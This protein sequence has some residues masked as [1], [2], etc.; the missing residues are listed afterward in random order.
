MS[1]LHDETDASVEHKV[2]LPVLGSQKRTREID[3]LISG[4]VA[5]YPLRVAI[6]CKNY[7]SPIG[8]EKIDEF[9]GKL[10]DVGIPP[11]CGIFVSVSGYTRD[12]L[13][14]AAQIGIRPLILTGLTADRLAREVARAFQSITYL[15]CEVARIQVTSEVDESEADA[16]LLLEDELGNPCGHLAD[17]I[18]AQWR[19]GLVP[20]EL[21]EYEIALDLPQGWHWTI[22][23]TMMPNVAR[24][25]VRVIGLVITIVGEAQR[26]ALSNALTRSVERLNVR[27]SFETG[28]QTFPVT[29]VHTE[30][31][32][33]E[34]KASQAAASFTAVRL[35]L[36]RIRFGKL[37]WPPS[38]RVMAILVQRTHELIR[39]GNDLSDLA[40]LISFEEIEGTDLSAAFE[41][42]TPGHPAATDP[43]WPYSRQR[44]SDTT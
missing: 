39:Q 12:A 33:E 2:R 5:E 9:K 43:D 20:R 31:E 13:D 40:R 10:E 3:V 29:V 25:T 38:D 18:W 17:L 28:Q 44:A 35:P 36:A 26:F 4:H 15:L 22:S 6:E 16:L 19:D 14:R 7:A 32:L 34:L 24:A 23:G 37:Y 30:A 42:I 41:P 11:Q 8:V 27:V 1:L 21:G